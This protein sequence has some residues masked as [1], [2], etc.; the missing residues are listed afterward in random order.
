MTEGELLTLHS[1]H[2]HIDV[3]VHLSTG[4]R[5][6][7]VAVPLGQGHTAYGRY[8]SGRGANAVADAAARAA[9]WPS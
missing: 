5:P 3:P 7:I 2:G 4:V 6:G 9:A 8:A 1:P